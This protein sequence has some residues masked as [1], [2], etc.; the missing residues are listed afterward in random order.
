LVQY[1]GAAFDDAVLPALAAGTRKTLKASAQKRLWMGGVFSQPL[2]ASPSRSIP[3]ARCG[4]G[5]RN[6][7]EAVT[8]S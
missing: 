1:P 8:L 6:T 2:R 7:F 5:L 4:S 3:Q